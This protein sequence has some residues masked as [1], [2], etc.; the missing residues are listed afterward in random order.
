MTRALPMPVHPMLPEVRRRGRKARGLGDAN[1][2]AQGVQLGAGLATPVITGVLASSAASTAAA[3]G[4]TAAILGMAP[5]LAVPIIGAALVGVATVVALLIKNSGCGITCVE[6]SQWANQAEPYLKQN[7]DAYFAL[8]S[9]RTRSQQTAALNVFDTVWAR[10]QQLCGQPGTGNA[11]ARCISDRQSGSCKWKATGTPPW[12][13]SPAV[14]S[15]WNWFNAY[16]DPI[17]NDTG[18]VDDS[19]AASNVATGAVTSVL[20]SVGVNLPSGS[21]LPLLLLGGLVLLAVT[22]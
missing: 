11:G 22:S 2:A 21:A 1:T 6:T 20:S 5:A 7:A 10:L 4:S 8:P 19:V 13:G 17:A 15:C 3:T 18:V 12:P 14:G 16:R 9:P